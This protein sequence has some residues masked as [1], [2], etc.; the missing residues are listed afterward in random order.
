MSFT[1]DELAVMRQADEEIEWEFEANPYRAAQEHNDLAK[2]LDRYA[3]VAA[4]DVQQRR[5]A[6]RKR[7]YRAEH[8]EEI[9][10]YQHKYYKEHRE[11]IMERQRK[12]NAE[13]KAE[14]AEYMREYMRKYREK[15]R[16][17]RAA[18]T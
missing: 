18:A 13:H 1:A 15:I 5:I 14:I 4:M 2:E 16:R 6:E 12:Y 7:K 3:T 10:D 11:A 8:K 9:A 17:E